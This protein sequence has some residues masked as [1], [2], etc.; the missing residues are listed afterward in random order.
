[1]DI[2]SVLEGRYFIDN[3][4]NMFRTKEG[5]H[6]I[7]VDLKGIYVKNKEFQ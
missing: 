7:I 2:V 1:M 6:R 5:M 3:L 4:E